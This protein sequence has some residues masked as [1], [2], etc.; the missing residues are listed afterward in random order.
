MIKR[1]FANG[2]KGM[3]FDQPLGQ[4]SI[5]VGKVGSGKSSR[6][7]ALALLVSGAMPNTGIGRTN[8][9]IFNAV[10]SGDSFTVGVETDDGKRLERIY[11]RGPKGSV[12]CSYRV[13]GETTPKNLFEL[14]LDHE[15]F[16]MADV[17]AFHALS[18]AKK[19]DE[20][21][22]LF[23]PQGDVRGIN[24][25][26]AQTKEAISRIEA[27][28]K[29]R[30]Q[31]CQNLGKAIADMELPAGT[32]PEIQAQIAQL[33][34]EYQEARDE[35]VREKTR[36][37]EASAQARQGTEA[38]E[39]SATQAPLMGEVAAKNDVPPY[40]SGPMDNAGLTILGP[41]KKVMSALERA[42][43]DACAAK[44]ILRR[45]I[46]NLQAEAVNG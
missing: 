45:E 23:P 11:R 42:G 17:A 14:E 38:R 16:S 31:S 6:S 46:K 40:K 30:E 9:D 18:D 20:L 5:L 33:E 25:V 32:L 29:A 22:R 24:A 43:C 19:I 41:L 4:R 39:A 21:F 7:L 3:D 1:I 12:S 10:A 8:A 44:M 13:D 37:E 36:R 35:M 26:I 34:R 28:I 27:D 15:G 2:F